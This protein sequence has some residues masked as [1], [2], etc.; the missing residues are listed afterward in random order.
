MRELIENGFEVSVVKD[1]TA[2]AILPG[3]NGYEAAL[4]NFRM[5]SS[6]VF[7]TSEVVEQFKK[8]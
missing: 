8:L 2:A 5:I 1:A 4:T 6:H 3:L 7:T